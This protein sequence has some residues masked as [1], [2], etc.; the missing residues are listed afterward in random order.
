M[1]KRVLVLEPYYGGSHRHF[2]VGLQRNIAA[3]YYVLTL[4]ARKWKMRMQLSAFWFAQQIAAL[5]LPQRSFDVVL[6]STFIDVAVLRA[7]LMTIEGWKKQTTFL[8]YFHENQFVYPGQ[9]VDPQLHQFTSINFTTAL[10]SDKCGFNSRYNFKSFHGNCEK[11]LKKASDMDLMDCLEEIEAKSSILYPGL[12]F[13]DF[14]GGLRKNSTTRPVIVWNHR[15]EHD[16]NPELFFE[17]LYGLKQQGVDFGLIVLGQ[18]FRSVPD[19]FHEAQQRLEANIMHFG[20]VES[21]QEYIAL[22][23][24]GDI[25]VSTALHEFFGIAVLEAVRAGCRPLL[26][27]SLSYPELYPEE[28]LYRPGALGSALKE[29]VESLPQF[30]CE[31]GFELTERYTWGMQRGDY[32]Q[33]LFG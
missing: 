10:A 23:H 5:A 9:I 6:C 1:S 15:W 8:T 13:S 30:T 26:P 7:R 24:Q 25:V 33:W 28:Y 11:Y 19:C 3:E 2:L 31:A 21:R 14:A 29:L 4:P 18:S 22:L 32:T 16:K 12:D 17:A 20:F 27:A